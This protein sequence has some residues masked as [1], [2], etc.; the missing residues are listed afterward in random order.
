MRDLK[1]EKLNL[2]HEKMYWRV[3]YVSVSKG[4]T[5]VLEVAKISFIDIAN[6]KESKETRGE[7]DT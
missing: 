2:Y 3:E 6:Y 1:A 5:I 4:I 7:I